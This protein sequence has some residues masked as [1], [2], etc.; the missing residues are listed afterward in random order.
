MVIVFWDF[1]MIVQ[2]FVSPQAKRILI[3]CNKHGIYEVL[4]ELPNNWILWDLRKWWNIRKISNIRRIIVQCSV[5]Q[6]EDFVNTSKNLLKNRNCFSRCA[7]FHMKIRVFF[8]YF[9]H[10]CRFTWPPPLGIRGKKLVRE[11]CYNEWIYHQCW[12]IN[13]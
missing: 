3:I 13:W 10:D 6:N 2:I 1:L 4:H 7:L 8:K 12:E 9:G 11:S 5:F